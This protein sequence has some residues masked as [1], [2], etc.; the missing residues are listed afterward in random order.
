LKQAEWEQD[1]QRTER[2]LPEIRQHLARQLIRVSSVEEDQEE[3]TDLV[4]VTT[5]G[6]KVAIRIRSNEYY[7]RYKGEFTIRCERPSGVSTELGKIKRG[8]GRYFFYG[9]AGKN[10]GDSLVFWTLMDL[11]IFRMWFQAREANGVAPG[12]TRN[13]KDRTKFRVFR[14][15]ELPDGFVIDSSEREDS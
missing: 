12:E 6:E 8:F 1:K 4:V 3:N 14:Y 5:T 11:N 2:Y 9:F 13:N 10:H 15:D 7:A